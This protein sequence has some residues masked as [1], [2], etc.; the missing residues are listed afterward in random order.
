[1]SPIRIDLR[2]GKSAYAPREAIVGA[3]AWDL[4]KPPEAVEVRLCWF[5][6]GKGTADA[7]VVDRVRIDHPGPRDRRE[8]QFTLPEAPHSFSG[9]L[10]SLIWAIEAVAEPSNEAGRIEFV[11]SPTGREILLPAEDVP[12]SD[13]GPMQGWLARFLG[14]LSKG[15]RGPS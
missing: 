5:T 9:K 3:A 14:R 4:D 12:D 11:L 1:V 8:F 15:A 10:I 13:S 6:R 2:D 7:S